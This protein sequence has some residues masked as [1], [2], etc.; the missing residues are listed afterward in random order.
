MQDSL[1]ATD[2]ERIARQ[3]QTFREYQEQLFLKQQI[4]QE[5]DPRGP[6]IG[7]CPESAALSRCV[8]CFNSAAPPPGGSARGRLTWSQPHLFCRPPP[9]GEDR[10]ALSPEG[11]ACSGLSNIGADSEDY[12]AVRRRLEAARIKEENLQ[13]RCA[14]SDG[15]RGWAPVGPGVCI[16]TPAH[17]TVLHFQ[18][19]AE[20]ARRRRMQARGAAHRHI[21]RPNSCT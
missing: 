13:V 8:G 14:A 11:P 20:A 1:Y 4:R 17:R 18:V 16:A 2:E 15:F 21:Q 5:I 9:T 12:N 3:Q 10:Q 19:A 6:P 7:F